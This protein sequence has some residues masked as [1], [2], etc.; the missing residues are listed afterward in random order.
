MWTIVVNG[1]PDRWGV[2]ISAEVRAADIGS[3]RIDATPLPDAVE[4]LTFRFEPTGP[5]T[6]VLV[7]EWERTRLAIPLA[8]R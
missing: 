6:G 3:F 2:P 4:R 5:A 7:Y 8:R 1:N